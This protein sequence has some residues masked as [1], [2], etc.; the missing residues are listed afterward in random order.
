MAWQALCSANIKLFPVRL[1]CCTEY[2]IL[3][4][5][6]CSTFHQ[7][8]LIQLVFIIMRISGQIIT[9]LDPS[10]KALREGFQKKY[11]IYRIFHGGYPFRGFL[12]LAI[13][14][15]N[16]MCVIREILKSNKIKSLGGNV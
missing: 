14:S 13:F 10:L 4:Y 2:S 7:V 5:Q 12:F 11:H 9:V 8:L 16:K 3:D 15:S 6:T 1:S